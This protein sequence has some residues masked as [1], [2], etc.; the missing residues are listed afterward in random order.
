M[1]ALLLCLL[2][3]ATVPMSASAAAQLRLPLVF[4]DHAV[5]QRDRAI[6][7]WGWTAPGASVEVTFGGETRTTAADAEGRWRVELAAR[8]VG[9]PHAL[10]VESGGERIVRRD[11]WM[12]DVWIASGQSNMEWPLSLSDGEI[13]PDPHVRHFKVPQSWSR[14]PERELAGGT[15]EVASDEALPDFSAVATA[16]AR[17][18]RAHHDVPI[19]ILNTSW[20]GS[21]IEAWMT[22]AMLSWTQDEADASIRQLDDA[23]R[24]QLDALRETI[25][26]LPT[27][28]AGW[29]GGAAPW[30]DPD[31]D[32]TSWRPIPVPSIWEAAGYEGLDG[33]AWYRA[34]FALSAE[35]AAAGV[36][37]GLGAIDDA[38]VTFVNGVEVG[39]L[40]GW[41]VPRRYTVAPHALRAGE[42]VLAIRVTDIGWGGGVAGDPSLVFLESAGGA[43]R[44]LPSSWRFRVG[45]VAQ[46]SNAGRHHAPTLLWNRMVAP[47]T[48]LP[49]AGVLWYQGESNGDT[50]EDAR[51]YRA[52][53]QSM[54]SGWRTAWDDP[55]LPFL[56]V[57]LANFHAPPET[58][59]PPDVWPIVRESQSAA[60]ALARTA[61]AV[62]IDVGD[63]DDIHPRDKA[64]V[65]RRLALAARQ[66]AYGELDLVASGPRYRDHTIADGRVSVAFDHADGLATRDGAPLGG[67]TVQD[68]DGSWHHAD[69][70]IDGDRVMVWSDAARQPVAVRYAWADNPADAT[71]VNGAGLPASPFRTD[72]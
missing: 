11:V 71:L 18:V 17:D 55:D 46:E 53:F 12:G 61:E 42:N 15:W 66:L 44:A 3:I 67:F 35:E 31:L 9:G 34:R 6:P 64:T 39:R 30:A 41:D 28:D 54:I 19:G 8:S 45:R 37:L 59:D 2:A 50:A 23:Q 43:R 60:L 10:A 63:A 40:E 20:G 56:W 5:L 49:V 29:A 47:L 68:A 25:G 26:D 27:E 70:R 38:D 72:G 33:T 14:Q 65:G 13:E 48:D 16:F 58:A 1:R 21:R 22:P 62:T 24:A 52:Q 32:D 69:A 36:A 7:V 57:Q 51:A 4:S